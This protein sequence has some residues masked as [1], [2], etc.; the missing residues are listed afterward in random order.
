MV[1]SHEDVCKFFA[2]IGSFEFGSSNLFTEFPNLY[3]CFLE[4]KKKDYFLE[5]KKYFNTQ[6]FYNKKKCFV[7]NTETNFKIL[8]NCI[9]IPHLPPGDESSSEPSPQSLSPSHK[10]RSS[11]H[12]RFFTHSNSPSKQRVGSV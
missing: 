12:R 5:G 9:N 10:Y 2:T 11:I 8:H 1:K 7:K 3:K 6:Y 4:K